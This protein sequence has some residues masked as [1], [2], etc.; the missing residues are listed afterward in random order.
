MYPKRQLVDPLGPVQKSERLIG[1]DSLPLSYPGGSPTLTSYSL[2]NCRGSG[3]RIFTIKGSNNNRH[4]YHHSVL[5]DSRYLAGNTST[6]SSRSNLQ[7]IQLRGHIVL[8]KRFNVYTLGL[9]DNHRY[10]FETF[11][12]VSKVFK[13]DDVNQS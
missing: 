12:P 1:V 7:E 3:Q 10:L 4:D 11:L 8:R 2:M 13:S 5:G 6:S 9:P